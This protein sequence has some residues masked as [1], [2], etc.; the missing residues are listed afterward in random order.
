MLMKHLHQIAIIYLTYLILNK[1][2]L[3]N[4]QPLVD[5]PQGI[6]SRVLRKTKGAHLLR[7][8]KYPYGDAWSNMIMV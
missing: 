2:K 7:G 8:R 1:R 4:K 3:D 5:P 6:V